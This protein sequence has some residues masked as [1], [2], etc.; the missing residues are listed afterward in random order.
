MDASFT[1]ALQ[2][3]V[4]DARVQTSIR[5]PLNGLSSSRLPES[6]PDVRC[7]LKKL[8]SLGEKLSVDR[9][10]LLDMSVVENPIGEFTSSTPAEGSLKE[11]LSPH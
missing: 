7:V 9:N 11:V 4:K 3:N 5:A 2:E 1:I 6:I 8:S 10:G